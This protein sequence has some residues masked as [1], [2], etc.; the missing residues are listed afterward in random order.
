VGRSAKSVRG[1][2]DIPDDVMRLL[3]R[4]SIADG[5]QAAL[6]PGLRTCSKPRGRTAMCIRSAA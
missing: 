5:L 2:A 3:T 1:G 4:D 6:P